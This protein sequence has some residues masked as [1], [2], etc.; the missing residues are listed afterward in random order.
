MPFDVMIIS[1]AAWAEVVTHLAKLTT[2]VNK[3]EGGVKNWMKWYLEVQERR[4][5]SVLIH[6]SQG[7]LDS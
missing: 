1:Q 5:N 2:K 3:I 4:Y 7:S 6:F